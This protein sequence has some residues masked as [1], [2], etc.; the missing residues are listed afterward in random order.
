MSSY[1]EQQTRLR[2]A[3]T[4][5]VL[6]MTAPG[7]GSKALLQRSTVAYGGHASAAGSAIVATAIAVCET[8]QSFKCQPDRNVAA[9]RVQ[10]VNVVQVNNAL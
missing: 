2:R 5:G 1:L 7:D 8:R 3:S 10:P 6:S 4:V 9:G